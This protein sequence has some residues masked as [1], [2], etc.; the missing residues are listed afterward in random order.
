MYVYVYVYV[1][2]WCTVMS[3]SNTA[4]PS[5]DKGA[6]TEFCRTSSAATGVLWQCAE[7]GECVYEWSKL[8]CFLIA[9]F[10]YVSQM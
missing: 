6:L 4:V 2:A 1:Y 8:K 10:K 9:Q 7:R 5:L 3:V